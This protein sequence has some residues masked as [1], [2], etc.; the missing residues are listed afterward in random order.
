[1]HNPI[2]IIVGTRPEVIKMIPVYR[3]VK[4][5]GLPVMLVST[6]QHA[7]LLAE[8]FTLFNVQPDIDLAL[9][10]PNQDLSYLTQV[11]VKACSDL[12]RELKPRLIL[13]QGDTTT[14]MAAALAAF[15]QR[16]PVGHVEAGLRTDDI[17]QPFPEELNRRVVGLFAD[18]HFAPTTASMSNLLSERVTREKVF[19]TGNTVVDALQHILQAI[20]RQEM[21]ISLGI[22]RLV[23]RAHEQETKIVLFTMHRREAF[24]NGI[25]RVLQTLKRLAQHYQNVT[26]VYPAHPNPNVQRAI[27]QTQLRAQQNIQLI[28]PVSYADLV[29][30]SSQASFIVTDS[31]GIQ[32]EGVSLGKSV[33]VLREKTERPEGVWEGAAH[34]VGLEEGLLETAFHKEMQKLEQTNPTVSDAKLHAISSIYGDGHAADRIAQIITSADRAGKLKQ[35]KDDS[36][37]KVCVIGLGYIGLPTAIVAAEHGYQVHGYDIDADKVAAINNADPVIKEPEIHERLRFV[38]DAGTLRASCDMAPADYYIIAVPTPFTEDKKADL[39]YVDA[40]AQTIATVLQHGATVILESTVPVGTTVR[41]AQMLSEKTKMTAGKDF[42]VAHCPER[43]L[44]GKIFHELV[45]NARVIGGVCKESVQR[46]QQFYQSFV[47]GSLYLTNDKTAEMVK[48]VENSSRDVAIAFANQVASMATAS[49]L[50]PYEV[51]ELANKHP[52]V[53]ILRPGCGVGGHCIAVDPWFLVET[54]PKHTTLLQAAREVNDA[55]P[56]EVLKTI[57]TILNSWTHSRK[58]V[59]ALMGLTY[60]QDVDDLRESPAMIIAQSMRGWDVC[61]TLVCEPHVRP[62]KLQETFDATSVVSPEVAMMR[63]DFV[64][65]LVAHTQFKE[66]LKVQ[67]PGQEIVDFCGLLH[68]PRKEGAEQSHMFWP[69]QKASE[70]EVIR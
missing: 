19:Y 25:L 29:Y 15:Y 51:I 28:D 7:S 37:K 16:I 66:I 38:V 22:A 59:V 2:L 20:T 48:L 56:Y 60:K 57:R 62:S 10:K 9:G 18:Y 47:K 12:Y 69:T 46:A 8:L 30:L 36:M 35:W 34:L 1:M 4:Q 53:N 11:V 39:S 54:F 17:T 70:V 31:G 58:P 41:L 52:R 65:L 40:A 67:R 55:K 32:E 63:A 14:I 13:V 42:F 45:H 43:V 21:S 24:G 50:N 6:G 64:V 49:G 5:Q 26:I 44:P 68:V 23:D 27:E 61:T 33:I 3:A